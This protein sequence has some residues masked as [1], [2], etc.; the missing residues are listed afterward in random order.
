[1]ILEIFS[2]PNDSLFLSP[3]TIAFGSAREQSKGAQAVEGT[4]LWPCFCRAAQGREE[5]ITI[6]SLSL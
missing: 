2:S 3:F 4:L 1:M 5:E 6:S